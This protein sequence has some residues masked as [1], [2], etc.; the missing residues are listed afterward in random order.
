MSYEHN[1][2][3]VYEDLFIKDWI[4]RSYV[5][6]DPN[7]SPEILKLLATDKD[8]YVRCWVAQ[9]PNTPLE[10]IQLLATDVSPYVRGHAVKNPNKTELIERLVLMT[11]YKQQN[12]T[13]F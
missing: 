12:V 9:N 6:R 4:Y 3:K 7:T 10:T 1:N 2:L 8:S 13:D 5:A 11:N